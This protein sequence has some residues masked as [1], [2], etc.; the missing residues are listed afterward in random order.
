MGQAQARSSAVHS[1]V[2]Q[3]QSRVSSA[4][5][6]RCDDCLERRATVLT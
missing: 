6:S 4:L 3:C 1:W 5:H 2:D